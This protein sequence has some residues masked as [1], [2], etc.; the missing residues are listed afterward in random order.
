MLRVRRLLL[1][2][3]LAAGCRSTPPKIDN[4][5]TVANANYDAVW[6]KTVQVVDKYFDI[7]YESRYDGRLETLPQSAAMLFEPWR[8]DSA[9]CYER[10]EAS[11]QTI[12][13]RA[14]VLVQ[15]APSGGFNVTVEVYKELEDLDR[16]VFTTFAG[17]TF[18]P[19]I[20]AV[21]EGL[22][23]SA[24]KPTDGWISLGRDVKLEGIIASEIQGTVDAGGP[25]E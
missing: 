13:R 11:L 4:P 10:L 24:I 14:F 6:E 25:S 1:L 15:P 17:G 2:L 19:A 7:A 20:Q 12:R 18:I 23:V 22:V 16:P 8:P 3:F 21:R 9:D 5:V